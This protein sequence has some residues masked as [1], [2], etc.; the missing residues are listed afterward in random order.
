M[1]I[2]KTYLIIILLTIWVSACN[3]KVYEVPAPDHT[4]PTPII[5]VQYRPESD[6]RIVTEFPSSITELIEENPPYTLSD[7]ATT[8]KEISTLLQVIQRRYL[9][10]ISKPGWYA[11]TPVDNSGQ[12]W[13]YIEDPLTYKIREVFNT[14]F[15]SNYNNPS[16]N[17][18]LLGMMMSDGKNGSF[19]INTHRNDT[20]LEEIDTYPRNRVYCLNGDMP[21]YFFQIESHFVNV[22]I[23]HNY[24]NRSEESNPY[25]VQTSYKAWVS[26]SAN[27]RILDVETHIVGLVGKKN[28]ESEA[29]QTEAVT[30]ERFD[31][32][33]GLL[34]S[35]HTVQKFTDGST[36]TTAQ[37]GQDLA[38]YAYQYYESL[39]A[40]VQ[41]LY[42][43]AARKVREAYA[44]QGMN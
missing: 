39:P 30:T 37:E 33:S 12:V 7:P 18:A 38:I 15:V 14:N 36:L 34:I 42:D 25:Q 1:K 4:L 19:T 5:S 17:N 23:N 26:G 21:E 44:T 40:K 3:R 43:D 13:V 11:S 35:S 6:S 9:A 27:D 2:R 28:N 20:I 32:N 24:I 10:G 16:G 29:R 41:Q 31:W 8:L 22:I